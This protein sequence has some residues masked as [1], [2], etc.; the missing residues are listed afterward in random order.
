[1]PGANISLAISL[2]LPD[3]RGEFAAL[4][5]GLAGFIFKR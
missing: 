2:L 1:L 3:A 5:R 4:G